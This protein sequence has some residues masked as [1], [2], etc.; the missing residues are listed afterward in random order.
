MKIAFLLLCHKNPK[1][2]NTFL[3]SLND[4]D[5]DIFIHIDKKNY[6]ISKELNISDN[7]HILNQNE[8]YDVKW[9]GIEMILATLKLI[10]FSKKFSEE[11]KI[12]YDYFWL[13]SGQDYIIQKKSYIENFLT[14]N[15]GKNFINI[16]N[17]NNDEYNRYKKLYEVYYPKWVTKNNMIIKIIKRIYM[18]ITGGYKYTIPI[19]RRKIPKNLVLYF[20]SQWWTLSN[21]AINYICNYCKNNPQLI[22]FYKNSIIPDESFFQTILMNSKYKDSLENNLTYVNWG[23]NRRSPE[24]LTENDIDKIIKNNKKFFIARKFDLFLSSK[25]IDK[26]NSYINGGEKNV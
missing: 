13:I 17:Q 8:C 18:I 11:N 14:N 10:D 4:F 21:D 3:Q 9:G 22:D 23:S 1:Q 20:G 7:I 16:I 12:N 2:I 24:I 25:L 26:I 5:C 19:F 15:K 6:V